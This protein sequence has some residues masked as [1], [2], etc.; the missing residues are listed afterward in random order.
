MLEVL[1][2]LIDVAGLFL[3]CNFVRVP[4]RLLLLLVIALA[5]VGSVV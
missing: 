5:D 2:I 1:F 4:E 3:S